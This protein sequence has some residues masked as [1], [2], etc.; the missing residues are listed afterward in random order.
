MKTQFKATA[1]T[2]FAFL[3][4]GVLTAQSTVLKS[5]LDKFNDAWEKSYTAGDAA[6]LT[7]LYTSDAE[8]TTADGDFLKGTAAIQADYKAYFADT[9]VVSNEVVISSVISIDKNT[10]YVTGTWKETTTDKATGKTDSASGTYASLMVKEDGA[11]KI[12]SDLS[13]VVSAGGST[14]AASPTGGKQ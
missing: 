6:S 10:A 8:V 5:E 11:W 7:K 9:K 2:L 13:S 1:L 4:T 12:K 3:L 14:D